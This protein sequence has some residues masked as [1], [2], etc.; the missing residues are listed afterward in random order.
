MM[1]K[2][3]GITLWWLNGLRPVCKLL[4]YWRVY[5]TIHHILHISIYILY[6]CNINS[7][8]NFPVLYAPNIP[9]NHFVHLIFDTAN[10]ISHRFVHSYR[11]SH[12]KSPRLVI[13]S[14]YVTMVVGIPDKVGCVYIYIID[15]YP[16][17][18]QCTPTSY[19][20]LYTPSIVTIPIPMIL[21]P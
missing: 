16:M 21:Y 13:Q 8:L 3:L 18:F 17:T 12:W 7:S 1:W 19:T 11:F 20:L 4:V 9:L 15:R 6:T 5:H 14:H 10:I 2:I